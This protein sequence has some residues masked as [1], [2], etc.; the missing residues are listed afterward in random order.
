MH[1][2]MHGRGSALVYSTC[3]AWLMP[4]L[5]SVIGPPDTV[6]MRS[7]GRGCMLHAGMVLSNNPGADA[8]G[9][10]AKEALVTVNGERCMPCMHGPRAHCQG[11]CM[12]AALALVGSTGVSD[13]V[14]GAARSCA[15]S[16][17]SRWGRSR[18]SQP[19]KRGFCALWC[20][21]AAAAAAGPRGLED[22]V[23]AFRSYVN[24]ENSVKAVEWG[25]W[26][27]SVAAAGHHII[28]CLFAVRPQDYPS[29]YK[30]C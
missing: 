23:E 24:A 27:G 7:A 15:V 29:R 22:Y 3:A 17:R 20:C 11:C 28:A 9:L 2:C 12:P 25:E 4:A 30:L 14:S 19:W 16:W 21:V 26:L 6:R 5:C 10:L 8:G 13:V 18:P 1:A